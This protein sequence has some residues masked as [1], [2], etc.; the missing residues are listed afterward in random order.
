MD[1]LYAV[2]LVLHITCAAIALGAS[3]GLGRLLRRSL[4]VGPASFA[5]AA[6][7]AARRGKL[8]FATYVGVFLTGL[9]LIFAIGGFAVAPLNIHLAL[10]LMLVVIAVLATLSRPQTNKLLELSK[11]SEI[12]K[13]AVS[14][15]MKKM[16][17][18]Q[19]ILHLSWLVL[20]VL[21]VVRIPK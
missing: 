1:P 11:P 2:L 7:D 10:G 15:A 5:V 6:E 13:A 12:D 17:M 4:E 9:G 3:L 20:L 16:Q 19:G 18:A 14:K 21:M 8:M